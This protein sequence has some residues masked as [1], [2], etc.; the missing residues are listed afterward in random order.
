[1]NFAVIHYVLYRQ[2]MERNHNN[3]R[4]NLINLKNYNKIISWIRIKTWFGY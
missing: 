2:K 1:M 3:F 4:M